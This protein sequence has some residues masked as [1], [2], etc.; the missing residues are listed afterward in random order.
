MFNDITKILIWLWL[1]AVFVIYLKPV[2]FV[3]W[4][5]VSLFYNIFHLFTYIGWSCE[6]ALYCSAGCTSFML[7]FLVIYFYR[8]LQSN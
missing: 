2:F 4:F 5:L 1:L 3:F 6:V 8:K 7:F